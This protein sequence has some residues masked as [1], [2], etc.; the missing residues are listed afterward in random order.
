MV[1]SGL[2]L[3]GTVALALACAG[4]LAI[5]HVLR[6]R[7]REVRVI[8]TLFWAHAA[9]TAR[10]RSL[11]HRFRHPWTYVL[12]LAICALLALALGKPEPSEESATRAWQP[13]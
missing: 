6:T 2:S 8:T 10:A 4:V 13:A 1:F 12:L 5:L 7:P 11:W 3:G 9:E